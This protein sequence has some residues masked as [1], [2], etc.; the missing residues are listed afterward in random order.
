MAANI[1]KPELETKPELEAEFLPRLGRHLA[2]ELNNPI[3]AISSAAFLIQDFIETAEGG[4]IEVENI[5]P[6]IESIGEECKKL[7]EIVEEFSKYVTTESVLAMPIEI[8]EFVR[9][10]VAELLKDGEP[11][12]F[13]DSKEPIRVVADTG[14]L[15]FILRALVAYAVQSGATSV[16]VSVSNGAHCAITI[17]DNRPEALTM[18]EK[19]DVFSPLPKRRT[20]GL[21]L[22]LPLVKKLIDLHRGSIE[23]VAANATGT[24]NGA[25][26]CITLPLAPGS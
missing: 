13:L 17:Q 22:K 7:K 3:S 9:M 20:S 16:T 15:Q 8:N 19:G 11:V 1:L 21:G 12:I 25:T 4:K 10:R 5:K 14:A 2:H 26:I 6:F 23:F 18:E 24:S